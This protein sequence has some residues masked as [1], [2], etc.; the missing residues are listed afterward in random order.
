M[1]DDSRQWRICDE[2]DLELVRLALVHR[3]AWVR[4]LAC[5]EAHVGAEPTRATI[6]QYSDDASYGDLDD[7]TSGDADSWLEYEDQPFRVS[8]DD[9]TLVDV[10]LTLPLWRLRAHAHGIAAERLARWAAWSA[11]IDWRAID[12]EDTDPEF[13][14]WRAFVCKALNDARDELPPA[15]FYCNFTAAPPHFALGEIAVSQALLDAL[16][17][18]RSSRA[19]RSPSEVASPL[20]SALPAI[21]FLGRV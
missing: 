20:G 2:A 10:D 8:G 11:A 4:A 13:V 15:E 5:V 14:A 9:D 21:R 3:D 6:M 1:L 12:R 7:Y 17:T 16:A 19:E 18:E